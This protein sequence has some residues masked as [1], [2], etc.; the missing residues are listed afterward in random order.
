[1]IQLETPQVLD[2]IKSLRMLADKLFTDE[3][4]NHKD[5]NAMRNHLDYFRYYLTNTPLPQ[6]INEKLELKAI[7]EEDYKT[8]LD[9][10]RD[11]V[12]IETETTISIKTTALVNARLAANKDALRKWVETVSVMQLAAGQKTTLDI[13]LF[14]EKIVQVTRDTAHNYMHKVVTSEEKQHIIDEHEKYQLLKRI[15][16]EVKGTIPK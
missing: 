7:E 4:V 14:S 1:M 6:T 2:R 15:R 5:F 12:L 13:D 10:K 16:E 3:E 9:D 11:M 8:F